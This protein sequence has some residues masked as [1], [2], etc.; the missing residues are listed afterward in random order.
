MG[1]KAGAKD[2]M[3]KAG[4]PCVPGYQGED[5]SDATMLTAAKRIGFPVM[6]KAVAGGGG[7]GM[8][9]VADEAHFRMRC[10][11]RSEAQSAFGDP[12]VILERAIIQP[13]HIEI[14]VFGDR[15]GN[16]IHLG[17]R[18]CSVQRRH[19]K[20]IEEAPSPAVSP[21][22]RA[23]MGATAVAAIKAINYEGAG[24]LE[25]LLDSAGNYYFMEMNTRLQ[26]EHPVT[27]PSPASIWSN[28]S[29]AW[30]AVNR[31]R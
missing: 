10:A 27:E 17:E 21:E 16:A 28:C 29:C 15:H 4:V 25:F 18:D 14:Q 31:S 24:T 5:Q 20:L 26:V 12:N 7:R 22:L 2:I 23:R 9:L 3:Q 11:R 6:I 1:H 13:R 19:Q 30:R 8:R